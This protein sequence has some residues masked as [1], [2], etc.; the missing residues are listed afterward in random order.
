[1]VIGDDHLATQFTGTLYPFIGADTRVNGNQYIRWVFCQCFNQCH[2]EPVTELKTIG[3]AEI[4]TGCSHHV[5][6]ADSKRRAGCTIGIKVTHD[7]YA[8][9]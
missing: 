1:M 2:A 3:D 6:G 8:L 7:Q 4:H 9:P 5:Q